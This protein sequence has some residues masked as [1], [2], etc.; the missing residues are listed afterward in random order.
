[1]SPTKII[2]A[3]LADMPPIPIPV[4]GVYVGVH[5]TMVCSLHCGL[6]A[7]LTDAHVPHGHQRVREVG[8]LRTYSAQE[9]ASWLASENPLEASIGMAAY[10]SLLE[11]EGL[12]FEAINAIEVLKKQGAGRNVAIVGHFPFIEELRPFTRNLWVLE[13]HPAPG[14]LPA[15]AAPEVLPQA[16]V[17]AITATTLINHT[18]DD[19]LDLC[20]PHAWR[21]LLGPS[22]PLTPRLF[23]FGFAM[24]SGAR[25]VDEKAALLTIQQ[26]AIFPQVQG[27]Q[28]LTLKRENVH[29]KQPETGLKSGTNAP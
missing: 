10:N 23:D 11:I 27:V 29:P 15:T 2:E 17:V 28:L 24:L 18:L 13:L 19:L 16:D 9:L 3:L 26:G 25:V 7:T 20:S 21:M 14:D 4:R 22:T 1:M 5:W 8:R 12:V 6:A